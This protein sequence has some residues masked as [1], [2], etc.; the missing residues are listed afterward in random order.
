[1]KDYLNDGR[2]GERL[3]EGVHIAIVGPP[4]A[5]K[6]SLINLLGNYLKT[7]VWMICDICL[8][9]EYQGW[10]VFDRSHYVDHIFS[11]PSGKRRLCHLFLA[12]P[13]MLL[14]LL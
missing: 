5:G 8:S 10:L 12:P 13:G 2:R 1:M 9:F 3:R 7:I 14:K 11:Q 4:N 6:S